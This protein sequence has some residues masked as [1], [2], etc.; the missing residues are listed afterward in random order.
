VPHAADFNLL[1]HDFMFLQK[2]FYNFLKYAIVSSVGR[3]PLQADVVVVPV[4][5]EC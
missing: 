5:A 1:L 3:I 2:I 4:V